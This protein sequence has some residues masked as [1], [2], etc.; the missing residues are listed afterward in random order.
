MSKGCILF[1]TAS[2]IAFRFMPDEFSVSHVRVEDIAHHLALINRFGGAGREFYSVLEHV[3][4]VSTLVPAKLQK[5]ALLHDAQ[6]AYLGDLVAPLK[7]AIPAY[8]EME[9]RFQGVIF[10]ALGVTWPDAKAGELLSAADQ[11]AFAAEAHLFGPPNLWSGLGQE[12]DPAVEATLRT[13]HSRSAEC[14][15][16]EFL[17]AFH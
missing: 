14:L 16:D 7:G 12:L 3:L 15:R 11:R 2:G 4:L 8:A 6:E 1:Y 10:D 17:S 13:I 5:A 9:R